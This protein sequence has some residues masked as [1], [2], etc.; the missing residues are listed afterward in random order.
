MKRIETLMKKML[1]MDKSITVGQFARIL[2]G[3]SLRIDLV[4]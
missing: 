3:Q 4:V 1:K 2:N